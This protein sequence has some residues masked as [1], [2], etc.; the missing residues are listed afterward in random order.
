MPSDTIPAD[1]CY[2][3]LFNMLGTP[4]S[5]AENV[6]GNMKTEDLE[7]LLK[8]LFLPFPA[9]QPCFQLKQSARPLFPWLDTSI[10]VILNIDFSWF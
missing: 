9:H 10:H 5:S 1:S 6:P 2:K 3:A 8:S 4:L 7:T